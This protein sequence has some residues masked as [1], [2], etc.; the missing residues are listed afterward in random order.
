MSLGFGPAAL[1]CACCCCLPSPMRCSTMVFVRS[2]SC[3]ATLRIFSFFSR[4]FCNSMIA[5]SRFFDR[6][7]N[8]AK[9]RSVSRRC[10]SALVL[11]RFSAALFAS[12]AVFNSC[13][14]FTTSK[15]RSLRPSRRLRNSCMRSL[16]LMCAIFVSDKACWSWRARL[17]R[18]SCKR[19]WS[20][21]VEAIDLWPASRRVVMARVVSW[22]FSREPCFSAPSAMSS[23]ARCKSLF[24]Q[25]RSFSSMAMLRSWCPSLAIELSAFSWESLICSACSAQISSSSVMRLSTGPMMFTMALCTTLAIEPAPS[26]G[27]WDNC[28]KS[29][30]SFM[31]AAMVAARSLT[32][33][34]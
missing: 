24:V 25:T 23:W 21:K 20:A 7:S 15:C 29:W 12:S 18:S 13:E 2:P 3:F 22:S 33:P 6:S 4:P 30:L 28:G 14:V 16:M 5:S 19:C 27:F 34:E 1:A 17:S 9:L 10:F 11:T 31:L 26:P 32:S 8:C